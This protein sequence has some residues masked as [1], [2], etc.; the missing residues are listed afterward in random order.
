LERIAQQHCLVCANGLLAKLA[1]GE[2]VAFITLDFT[3]DDRLSCESAELPQI[4]RIPEGKL[5]YG[6]VLDVLAHLVR[7]AEPIAPPLN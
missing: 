5:L 3:G 1:S 6:A 4:L 2:L 7:G